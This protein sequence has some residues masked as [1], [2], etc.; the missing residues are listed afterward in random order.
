MAHG[1]LFKKL[2]SSVSLLVALLSINANAMDVNPEA[3]IT[4]EIPDQKVFV[5]GPRECGKGALVHLMMGKDLIADICMD[6][7]LTPSD[8]DKLP[9]IEVGSLRGRTKDIST[10]VD[11]IHNRIIY[12]CPGFTR[13]TDN[14]KEVNFTNAVALHQNLEGDIRIIFVIDEVSLVTQY[15]IPF[16][17]TM[18]RITEMFPDQDEL[19]KMI[20]LVVSRQRNL[21][22]SKQLNEIANYSKTFATD[23]AIDLMKFLSTNPDRIGNF[24]YPDKVG[25]YIVSENL[26]AF[27]NRDNN[28]D[29]VSNPKVTAPV[30]E[31]IMNEDRQARWSSASSYYMRD[32]K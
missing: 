10:V 27:M 32:V 1:S 24:C 13:V 28:N 19:K 4:T 16:L 22:V 8:S 23:R 20:S 5:I 14:S 2:I 29:Y 26:Q 7:V 6:W 12:D 30:E 17:L 3:R 31:S 9:N 25:P 21:D 15:G 18:N 11:P